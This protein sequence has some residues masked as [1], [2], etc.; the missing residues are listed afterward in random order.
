M[1]APYFY[2]FSQYPELASGYGSLAG[3]IVDGRRSSHMS[4][5]FDG[6]KSDMFYYPDDDLTIIILE[7]L[8]SAL[9]TTTATQ[10]ARRILENE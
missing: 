1:F 2:S 7:N 6:F 9:P 5:G 8:G 10:V 4:G 3:G